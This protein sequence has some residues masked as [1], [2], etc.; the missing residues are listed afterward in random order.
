RTHL[1]DTTATTSVVDTTED[2]TSDHGRVGFRE[3]Q[4]DGEKATIDDVTV[5]AADGTVLLSDDFSDGLEK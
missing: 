1:D 3:G 2:A 4:G 5:T